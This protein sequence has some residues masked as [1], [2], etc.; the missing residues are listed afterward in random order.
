VVARRQVC[1]A[2]CSTH[3]CYRG[4]GT[5]A[6]CTV[7]HHPQLAAEAHRC[8][9]CLDCLRSCPHA[10][11]GLVLRPP[12]ASAWRLGASQGSIAPF[13]LA[14]TGLA[15]LFLAASTGGRLGEPALLAAA[16]VAVVAAAAVATS[17]L[18][19]LI[20]PPHPDRRAIVDR[21]ATGLA[22]IAWGPLMALQ[23][24]HLDWCSTVRIHAATPLG[25]LQLAAAPLVEAGMIV[26][27]AILGAIVLW[28]TTVTAAH[29]RH[30][31]RPVAVTVCAVIG[32]AVTVISLILI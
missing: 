5:V 18:P 31:I 32:L 11:T 12:L 4:N 25:S 1:A 29:D 10:S 3:E 16:A 30:P 20:G 6:G 21:L 27:A 22:I 2:A 19:T 14:L 7:F 24:H 9:L 26:V 8:K 28:R 13:A 23:I 17:L 15:P